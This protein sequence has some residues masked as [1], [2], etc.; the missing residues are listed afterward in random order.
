MNTPLDP[1]SIELLRIG[2]IK[3]VEV[4]TS[5]TPT[6]TPVAN[7]TTCDTVPFSDIKHLCSGKPLG[8]FTPAEPHS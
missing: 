3:V 5:P 8:R 4:F 1:G 7:S 2:P 6:D